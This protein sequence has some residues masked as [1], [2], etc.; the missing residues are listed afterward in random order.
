MVAHD[1]DF[2]LQFKISPTAPGVYPPAD[3]KVGT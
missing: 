2:V 3:R 1:V